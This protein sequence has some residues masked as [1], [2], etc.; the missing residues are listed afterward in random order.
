MTKL[1][2]KKTIQKFRNTAIRANRI[3]FDCLEIHMAHGYLLH[4][5]LSPLSNSRNDE[6]GGSIENRMRF[7]VEVV[8]KVRERIG[9]NIPLFVRISAEDVI[10]GDYAVPEI[11]KQIVGRL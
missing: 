2:I 4:S 6:Y 11:S 1:Q 5:F 8:K 10:N 9:E 3:N 7:P